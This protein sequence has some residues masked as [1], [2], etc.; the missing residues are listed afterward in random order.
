M[1]ATDPLKFPEDP[2]RGLRVSAFASRFSFTA[3]EGLLQLCSELDLSELSPE[4]ILDELGK[5]LH[6][7]DPARG[8]RFLASTGL[9]RFLPEVDALRGTPQ[10]SE[11]HPEGDVFE[12]TLLA[13][14]RAVELGP[15]D[16]DERRTL[17]F[18]TLC[19][20]QGAG[21]GS[22]ANDHYPKHACG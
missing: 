18:A 9:L 3:D 5:I 10:D 21:V 15:A 17:L 19:H 20:D 22:E 13:L 8:F 12:H 6:G 16:P 11:W 14:D 1:R 2:L 4:R 7:R